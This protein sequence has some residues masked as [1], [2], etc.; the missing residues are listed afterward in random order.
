MSESLGKN[1]HYCDQ[2]VGNVNH[3]APNCP[4]L[5]PEPKSEE[6]TQEVEE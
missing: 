5:R 4:T 3:H 2:C 6:P 1:V